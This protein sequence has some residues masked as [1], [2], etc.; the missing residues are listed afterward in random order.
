MT[1]LVNAIAA[2]PAVLLDFSCEERFRHR[3]EIDGI[4]WPRSR[5]GS[6]SRPL[7]VLD[8]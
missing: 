1:D 7:A 4:T 2:E 3:A 5:S 8:R 6:P